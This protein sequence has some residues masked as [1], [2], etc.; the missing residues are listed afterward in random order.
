MKKIN[1]KFIVKLSIVPKLEDGA[2]DVSFKFVD[3]IMKN[4]V[5][6]RCLPAVELYFALPDSYPSH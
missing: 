3:V 2:K 6:V 4:E 5:T 1:I